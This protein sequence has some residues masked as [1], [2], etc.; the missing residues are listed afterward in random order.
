MEV[1]NKNNYDG[2]PQYNSSIGI[3]SKLKK[4]NVSKS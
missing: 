4:G 3:A 2:K 1:I